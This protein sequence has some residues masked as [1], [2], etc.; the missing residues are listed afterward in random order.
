MCYIAEASKKFPLWRVE[1][2]SDGE[3]DDLFLKLEMESERMRRKFASLVSKTAMAIK[4]D[5]SSG[6]LKSFFTGCSMKD[7]A[8]S[9]DSKDA[10][11]TTMEK[12]YESK[13]WSFFDYELLELIIKTFCKDEQIKVDLNEYILD[14]Q[15]FCKRRLYEVPIEIFNMKLPHVHPK[16]KVVMKIDKEFF[17][18]DF[19]GVK[20]ILGGEGTGGDELMLSLNR[21]KKIQRRLSEVLNVENLIFLDAQIGCIELIFRHFKGSNPLLLLSTLKKINL[22]FIGVTRIHCDAEVYDLRLYTSPPPSFSSESH[23]AKICK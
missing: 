5:T 23:S 1:H 7:L 22:A 21:I 6:D 4:N 16:A 11:S 12:V 13:G 20:S 2:L 15:N 8:N 3:K 17:G 10:I 19:N 14:F 9:I 18:E